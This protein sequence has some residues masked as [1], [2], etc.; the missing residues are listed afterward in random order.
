MR[1]QVERTGVAEAVQ[2]AIHLADTKVRRGAVDV[3]VALVDGL[4]QIQADQ[5]QLT[6]LF[7]NLLINAYE[8]MNGTGRI[9]IT[10]DRTRLED[11]GD[12]RD[13]VLIEVRDDGPGIA[14]DVAEKVF[15]PFFTTKPQGSG[16]GLAIVRKIVDA[17]DGRIDMRTAPGQGTTIRLM[18]PVSTGDI[19]TG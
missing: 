17:H 9:T 7:T 2:G 1:L 8:A 4:P 16:L 3:R 18:L 10:G 14:P 19:V 5:H 13:A 12:G 6:Q 15:D 11:G